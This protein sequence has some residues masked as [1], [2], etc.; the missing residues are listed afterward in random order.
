MQEDKRFVKNSWDMPSYV[1][2]WIHSEQQKECQSTNEKMET[3]IYMKK[4]DAKNG[5]YSVADDDD[6]RIPPKNYKTERKN[7]LRKPECPKRT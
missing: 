1:R 3:S 4:E 5:L 2:V 7:W 6:L